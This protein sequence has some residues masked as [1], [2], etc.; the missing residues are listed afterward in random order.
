MTIFAELTIVMMKDFHQK[1]TKKRIL[2]SNLLV[3]MM[4]VGVGFEF[5][6]P[7]QAGSG[8]SGSGGFGVS[9]TVGF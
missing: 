1:T 2:N 7:H 9:F 6:N 3:E 5:E 4:W 8:F